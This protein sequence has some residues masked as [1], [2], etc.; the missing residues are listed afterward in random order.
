MNPTHI[1]VKLPSQ[2]RDDLF[3]AKDGMLIASRQVA[4]VMFGED[5]QTAGQR[6]FLSAQFAYEFLKAVAQLDFQA[7]PPDDSVPA[8]GVMR[9]AEIEERD[10][11]PLVKSPSP[12]DRIK[13]SN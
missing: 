1:L 11:E 5:P 6:I 10:G 9:K 7:N 8:E 3:R 12:A 2:Q 13:F 4:N